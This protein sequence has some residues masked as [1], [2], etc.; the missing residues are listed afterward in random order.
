MPAAQTIGRFRLVKTLASSAQGQ[1]YLADDPHLQRRVTIKTVQLDASPDTEKQVQALLVEARLVSKL[2]HPNI[3]A[4]YDADEVR[5]TPYLV[6]EFVDG[7]TL[8][9]ALSQE[10]RVTLGRALEIAL[11]ILEGVGYAHQ[12]KVAHGDLRPANV[13][14]DRKDRARVMNFGVV[15][16]Q[17]GGPSAAAEAAPYLAPETVPES[18][19]SPQGDIFSLGMILYEMLCGAA[20]APDRHDGAIP[21]PS[22]C[23]AEAD[24]PLDTILFKALSPD[25]RYRYQSAQEMIEALNAYR[26]PPRKPSAAD[27]GKGDAIDFLLG[28]MRHKSDFP[29]LSQ[30]IST[31]NK[32]V[33]AEGKGLMILSAAVLKDFALTNKLL[34]LVNSA[35]YGQYGT[36]ST[37]SRAVVILGFDAIR[38]LA[39]T[40][41]LFENLQNKPHA[42]HLKDDIVASLYGA[43]LATRLQAK[44]NL[45]DSEEV[46]ICAMFH[47]LG[48]LLVAFYFP[49]EMEEIQN[50]VQHAGVDEDK[51][52]IKVLG[53]NYEEMGVAVAHAW[54]FPEKIIHSMQ[55]L[56][57]ERVRHP[58]SEE[59]KLQVLAN[60]SHDLCYI[61]RATPPAEKGKRL[62]ALSQRYAPALS[63]PDSQATSLIEEA[64]KELLK[65]SGLLNFD[66]KESD[67]Y[68]KVSAWAML[69]GLSQGKGSAA[70]AA[71]AAAGPMA[72][73]EPRLVLSAGLQ[74]ITDTL[75]GDYQLNDVLLIILE[76][77]YRAM[78]FSR[79]LLCIRDARNN[80]MSARFGLGRDADAIV[81][82]FSFPLDDATPSVFHAAINQGSDIY[83]ADIQADAI[84]N[85]IPAWYRKLLPAQS[86]IVF[87]IMLNNKAIGLFY[88]DR[89]EPGKLEFQANELGLL[90]ALRNQAILA[91]KQKV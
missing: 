30:T 57:P 63:L 3:V 21:P 5:G 49:E 36:I 81:K 46:F 45:R 11:Q 83:I 62:L 82:G 20:L 89:D 9:E 27:S 79:A 32:L 37:V 19:G 13:M 73:P 86:F 39:M 74:D 50:Q 85:R 33:A 44:L 61:A 52:A 8:R 25:P 72:A 34:R 43:I 12:H 16:R 6:F 54:N 10:G 91:I 90:K 69:A 26:H 80:T 7:A 56:D 1:V 66:L 55:K 47:N 28:R 38:S 24:A 40:L 48:R 76:T 78:G 59:D 67:F 22:Q 51:A 41:I 42:A 14:L 17:A 2:H 68:A 88:G 23:N 4:L 77:M 60:L 53:V 64:L 15:R 35:A 58:A 84:K 70:A 71:P 87:P 29:A 65:E 31:I 18:Q 75:V